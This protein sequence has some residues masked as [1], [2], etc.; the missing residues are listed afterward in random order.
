MDGCEPDETTRLL[1]TAAL[2]PSPKSRANHPSALRTILSTAAVLLI[3]NIGSHIALVPQTVILQDIVCRNYYAN[4]NSDLPIVPDVNRCK[5][6]PVQSE[7]AYINGWKDSLEVVP[8]TLR[9]IP[10]IRRNHL[11]AFVDRAYA[12]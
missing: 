1:D 11:E 7:V 10:L 2:A 4:V 5:V 3:L 9:V 12:Y 8:G 6:E